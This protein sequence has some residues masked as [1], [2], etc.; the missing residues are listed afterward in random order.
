MRG[1]CTVTAEYA[2][3]KPA[4]TGSTMKILIDTFTAGDATAVMAEFI[5]FG[6]DAVE[7]GIIYN[8]TKIAMTR[9]GNQ[10]TVT[11]DANDT[12]KGYAIVKTGNAFNLIVDGEVTISE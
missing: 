1:L 3:V 4:Y 10:F 6:T 7:K 9:Q 5:G 11:G 8:G 12:F 2:D